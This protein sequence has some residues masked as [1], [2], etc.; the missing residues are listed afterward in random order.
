VTSKVA[1]LLVLVFALASLMAVGFALGC[2]KTSPAPSPKADAIP[3][4]PRVGI[5]WVDPPGLHRI[6][7]NSPAQKARYLVPR[8]AGDEEDGELDVFHS[9]PGQRDGIDSTIASWVD[10]FSDVAAGDV[11]RAEREAKGLHLRTIEIRRGTFDQGKASAG[12]SG[13]KKDY[14]LEG[15]SAEGPSGAYLFEMTGPARTIA[16]ARPAFVQLVDSVRLVHLER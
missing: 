3:S 12:G 5:T 2:R 7:P 4:A 10:A 6:P 8:A 9:G 13:P 11:T 1:T 16:A 15:A 14:A